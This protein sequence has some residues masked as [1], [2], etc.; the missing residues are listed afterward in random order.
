MHGCAAPVVERPPGL[1]DA[2]PADASATVQDAAVLPADLEP[3]LLGLL[4]RCERLRAGQP[5]IVGLGQFRRRLQKELAFLRKL[6]A[7]YGSACGDARLSCSFCDNLAA[8][9]RLSAPLT[10]CAQLQGVANNTRGLGAELDV[11]ESA[12]GVVA[13][14]RRFWA[15]GLAESRDGSNGGAAHCEVDVVLE[16]AWVEV[17]SHSTFG[18]H[19]QHWLGNSGHTKGLLQQAAEQLAIAAAPCNAV[20]WTPPA[21]VFHF[22]GGV[23]ADV[24]H[25]LRAMGI[26]VT[27]PGPISSDQLPPVPPPPASVNLDVT[28]LCALVSELTN[29]DPTRADLWAWAARISHWRECLAAEVEAPLHKIL[30]PQLA[31]RRLLAAEPTLRQFEA[32][33]TKLGGPRELAR[34]V[35]LRPLISSMGVACSPAAAAAPTAGG[36]PGSATD[37]APVASAAAPEA[38]ASAE[39]PPGRSST[40][41]SAQ[42]AADVD[43]GSLLSPSIAATAPDDAVATAASSSF[44]AAQAPPQQ[45]MSSRVV[46]WCED[47][48][49]GALTMHPSGPGM[50]S[51]GHWHADAASTDGVTQ[52]SDAGDGLAAADSGSPPLVDIAAGRLAPVQHLTKEVRTVLAVGDTMQALTLTANGRAVAAAAAAGV[53]LEAFVHRAVWLTGF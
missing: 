34:W 36:S 11:A 7:G 28:T 37:S 49:V 21:I 45:H 19:S 4:A 43:T 15:A 10:V 25:E 6:A 41:T 16:H 1:L 42:A 50:L 5:D 27:G 47:W 44:D 46:D 35:R 12:P 33:V 38:A 2:A 52:A 39:D 20:R 29:A 3:Q 32:L 51:A 24:A 30:A 14:S 26:T 31:G 22:S 40:G 8:G 18:L 9:S 17:K 53:R 13:V 23:S 48:A